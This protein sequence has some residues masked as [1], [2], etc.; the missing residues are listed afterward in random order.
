MELFFQ[1]DLLCLVSSIY[2]TILIAVGQH[3]STVEKLTGDALEST[4]EFLRAHGGDRITL[5]IREPNVSEKLV[6]T[7]K[8]KGTQHGAHFDWKTWEIEVHSAVREKLGSFEQ[9]GKV[10]EL[11]PNAGNVKEF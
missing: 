8:W 6:C 11:Y 3:I 4:T 1:Y 10:S 5:R 9:T 2:C 7:Q